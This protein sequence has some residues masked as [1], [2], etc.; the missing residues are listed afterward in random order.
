M[1]CI[2][3]H[4]KPLLPGHPKYPPYAIDGQAWYIDSMGE[5]HK[6]LKFTGPKAATPDPAIIAENMKKIEESGKVKLAEMQERKRQ[7]KI[8]DEL[9]ARELKEQQE[10][11]TANAFSVLPGSEL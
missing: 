3:I 5:R 9:L 11:E 2:I 10:Y 6:F 8:A 7:N 4:F 1:S